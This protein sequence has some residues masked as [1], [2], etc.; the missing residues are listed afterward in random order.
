MLGVPQRHQRVAVF[1]DVL[2]VD[3]LAIEPVCLRHVDAQFA[4]G[5]EPH[6]EVPLRVDGRHDQPQ[7]IQPHALPGAQQRQQG[8]ADVD[9][10]MADVD[11]GMAHIAHV[12]A[13]ENGDI[14][15]KFVR[16]DAPRPFQPWSISAR[17]P[18]VHHDNV[19]TLPS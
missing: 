10:G 4:V 13:A 12:Q 18:C 8:M 6:H 19:R 5:F 16:F 7:A 17:F 3:Y 1:A 2:A 9:Q 14:L 15:G 11:Q